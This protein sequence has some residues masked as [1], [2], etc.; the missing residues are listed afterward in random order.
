MQIKFTKV[1]DNVFI[2]TDNRLY[3]LDGTKL[4]KID[5]ILLKILEDANYKEFYLE[6][7][8]DTDNDKRTDW[9]MLFIYGIRYSLLSA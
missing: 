5:N 2:D 3:T 6:L 9:L 7:K 1:S 8:K 4:T